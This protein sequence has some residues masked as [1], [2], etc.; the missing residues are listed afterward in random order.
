MS[1]EDLKKAN[2]QMH[3]KHKCAHS[4]SLFDCSGLPLLNSSSTWRKLGAGGS[5]SVH[6]TQETTEAPSRP[7]VIN[8]TFSAG[9]LP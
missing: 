9:P 3:P 1:C 4:A 5:N 6:G 7:L 8:S 2:F